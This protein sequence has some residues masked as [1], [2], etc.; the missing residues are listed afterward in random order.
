MLAVSHDRLLKMS[1]RK[2]FIIAIALLLA[3]TLAFGAVP[4][5]LED[6][7]VLKRVTMV[8]MSPSG[9]R[10]AYLLQVPRELYTEEDG[11]AHHELYVTDLEGNSHPYVTGDA[12]ITDIAWSADS[13]AI[14]FLAQRDDEA[15]F[16]S[17]YRIALTGGEA[18]QLFTHVNSINRIHPAPDGK[19]LAFT[20]AGAPPEKYT[21]LEEKGFKALVYEE[22]AL[23]VR[24]WLLEL[25]SFE[26]SAYELPGSASDF[27][28]SAD[29]S[30]YAVA[31]AP[32]P[33][34]DDSF[35]YRD[36]YVV[37][38]DSGK[39]VNRVGAIGKIGQFAFSP[40]GDR[41][42]YIGSEGINDPREGRLFAVSVTGGEPLELVPDYLGHVSQLL[43]DD[44]KRV[45]WV[46]YRGMYTDWEKVRAD[47]PRPAGKAPQSGPIIRAIDGRPGQANVAAIAHS[48]QHPSEV[49]LLRDGAK[50]KRLTDSNPWLAERELASQRVINYPSRDGLELEAVLIEP[51][52]TGPETPLIVYAHGGPESNFSNGWLTYYS[53]P[54][55]YWAGQGYAVVYPNYRGST[56]RGVAF[57][58]L[59]QGNYADGEF[60][61][62]VDA[63][64]HLVKE[65]LADPQR[66]GITGGSYGGYA[67][68]WSASALSEEYAAAVAFV[69]I[70]NQISKF[71][72]G[73]IPYEMYHVHSRMWPW[74][75]W[76]WMLE[77]SP[78][79]HAGKTK[80]PLLIMAGDR[81]PRV[82]PSQSLEM[83]RNVKLRTDTPV[84]L[85][86]YPG[87]KHGNEH[88][89]A[90]YDYSLRLTRW[91]DHYLKGPGG[92]APPYELN[93]AGRLE[94]SGGE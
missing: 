69:G 84:R 66:T 49:Y 39:V 94:E 13:A 61:D 72:T 18:E 90:Q 28:W 6:I 83:Y 54:G 92:E 21:E 64:R 27:V 38:R 2:S 65:G 57:T 68:M 44:N 79:Y 81:D 82:N 11:P 93:H 74:E 4:L 16:N 77:R 80:T 53:G 62:L 42:A 1:M 47:R 14:Y 20:A 85:V 8:R 17:L 24:V 76:M 22:S 12:D 50:P 87:E 51:A 35:M 70:S 19:T 25:E 23:P 15:E 52:N 88:T 10:I 75:D 9:E 48:P 86:F 55:Q 91:M 29:G 43:W 73:D 26:A 5:S 37:N 36:I 30:R 60:N 89:A 7:A 67:S 31:L 59:H 41:L 63:K 58:K 34:V 71:G 78:V 40:N 56:G 32:T 46:G 33:L 45:R 3:T